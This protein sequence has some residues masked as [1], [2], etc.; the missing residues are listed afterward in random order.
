MPGTMLFGFVLDIITFR[1]IQVSTVFV[2][3]IIHIVLVGLAIVVLNFFDKTNSVGSLSK[4]KKYLYL[5]SPFILQFSFG[6]LFGSS[7]I[8]FSFSGPLLI[9]WPFL[10]ILFVLMVSNELYR[11]YYLK[12]RIQM[13]IYFFS[14]YS[15]LSII[16]PFIF[17]SISPL[18]FVLS[19]ILSLLFIYG[20]FRLVAKF[21]EVVKDDKIFFKK[22]IITIFTLMNLLYFL[23][24]IPPVPLIVRDSGIYHNIV[25]RASGYDISAE[26]ETFFEKLI[27]GQTVHIVSGRPIYAYSAVYAPIE[28]NTTI[29]H[30][31]WRYDAEMGW[32]SVDRL[33]YPIVG[34]RLDGY[35]GYSYLNNLQEGKWRV[36][37]ETD[38]GQ[39]MGKINFKVKQVDTPREID[40]LYK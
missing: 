26:K 29:I 36:F 3:L 17:H 9:S 27:P 25:N 23:N 38:R 35:R 30:H 20:F 16:L 5:V 31:W 39:V 6:A 21:S 15:T 37:I 33:R 1:T 4:F 11:Q 32:I 7:L 8:F 28:L 34:G 2:I 12:P 24:I 13:S 14:F 18:V 40:I 22:S 19:G 10:L